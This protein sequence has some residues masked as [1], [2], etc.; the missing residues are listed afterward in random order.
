[1]SDKHTPGPWKVWDPVIDGGDIVTAG[2]WPHVM[3]GDGLAVCDLCDWGSLDI[4]EQRANSR[5]ISA[6]PEMLG[7]L[8]RVSRVLDSYAE[9]AFAELQMQIRAAI[10]KAA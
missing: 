3:T 8:V 5:L 10:A 4:D 2:D 1:M 6:A 9:D 7:A